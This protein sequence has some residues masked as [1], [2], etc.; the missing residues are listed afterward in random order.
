MA[1]A[2]TP[3]A[4]AAS[5]RV[6]PNG[7]PAYPS[8]TPDAVPHLVI[9]GD[10]QDDARA[11]ARALYRLVDAV[12]DDPVLGATHSRHREAAGHL[13]FTSAWWFS[14][15]CSR[16]SDAAEQQSG[17]PTRVSVFGLTHAQVDAVCSAPQPWPE[18]VQRLSGQPTKDVPNAVRTFERLQRPGYDLLAA[19]I[20]RYSVGC[21]DEMREVSQRANRSWAWYD[22]LADQWARTFGRPPAADTPPTAGPPPATGEGDDA[23]GD[24]IAYAREAM[25]LLYGRAS[26][27]VDESTA[28]VHGVGLE[29]REKLASAPL[30]WLLA[31][32]ALFSIVLPAVFAWLSS[33]TGPV[34][35]AALF[36]HFF[37]AFL[38]MYAVLPLALF[39][40][41]LEPRPKR[42]LA[43]STG[44]WLIV[45]GIQLWIGGRSDVTRAFWIALGAVPLALALV[46]LAQQIREG[47]QARLDKWGG[48]L[49]DP[50]T[51]VVFVVAGVLALALA[52]VGE[53]AR[54]VP[55][56][57]ESALGMRALRSRRDAVVLHLAGAA[58]QARERDAGFSRLFPRHFT[59]ADGGLHAGIVDSLYHRFLR[60]DSAIRGTLER[61][62]DARAI[63]REQS[64][65]YSRLLI[66]LTGT[67]GRTAGSRRP[68]TTAGRPL[69]SAATRRD[70]AAL[71]DAERP[72][73]TSTARGAARLAPLARD[74]LARRARAVAA[75]ER[76]L[77]ATADSAYLHGR[78][79]VQQIWAA[80]F[81]RVRSRIGLALLSALLLLTVLA[82]RLASDGGRA[83]ARAAIVFVLMLFLPLT[84][85][86]D[87]DAVDPDQPFSAF[88]LSPWNAPAAAYDALTADHGGGTGS[89]GDGAGAETPTKRDTVLVVRHDSTAIERDSLRIE[90][91][92]QP[93]RESLHDI[94]G[95]ARLV[96]AR[97]QRIQYPGGS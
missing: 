58:Q 10:A 29:L 19:Y 28:L 11:R 94:E 13:L 72:I 81:D 96:G 52:Y 46:A 1:T 15:R 64:V 39:A 43:A 4:P 63:T 48:L 65:A 95:Y 16:R 17:V 8:F 50:P 32:P 79:L 59:V 75:S 22:V 51:R 2:S 73:D 83:V 92:L 56:F 20:A 23:R 88:A 68:G 70:L 80:E 14:R 5:V 91:Q 25:Q 87:P 40:S 53:P 71:A 74:T 61:T 89:G 34:R 45:M 44:V 38:W 9:D 35:A 62:D 82:V 66:G 76:L 31:A 27:V 37:R 18:L 78:R 60:A 21:L 93:I 86:V 49:H 69:D 90:R 12:M 97:T 55:A 85:R 7:V 57:H 54:Y 77:L 6:S 67:A 42:A 36:P 24:F 33:N 30:A 84:R 41:L 26:I 3:H 47:Q